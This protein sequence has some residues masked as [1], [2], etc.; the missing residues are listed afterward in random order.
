M[1]KKS[2]QT[3]KFVLNQSQQKNRIEKKRKGITTVMVFSVTHY[4]E[5]T[6]RY[7]FSL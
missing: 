1:G 2:M 6:T 7:N 3:E 4:L 5:I